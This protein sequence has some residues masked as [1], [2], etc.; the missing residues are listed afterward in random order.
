MPFEVRSEQAGDVS[1]IHGVNASAFSTPAEANLVDSLRNAGGMALSLVAENREGIVGHLLLSLVSVD[2]INTPS[3]GLGPVAVLPAFQRR[4]IGSALVRS[5]LAACPSLGIQS[6][7]VLGHPEY[8]PRFGFIPASRFSLRFTAE[9]PDAAFLA[10]EIV[11]G[12][13]AKASGLVRFRP[14]FD[15][16]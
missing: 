8:Y 10:V 11:P 5:A 14:E 16:V 13:L 7:F 3:A 4:G 12:C 9:V 2:G 1:G 15:G 6:V